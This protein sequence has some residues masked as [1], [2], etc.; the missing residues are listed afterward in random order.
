MEDIYS[1]YE[2]IV[3]LEVHIQLLTKSKAYSSDATEYGAAPNTQVSPVSLGLPGTLPV[4]NEKVLEFAVKI[5]LACECD[6][7]EENEFARKNYFYADL[8]KGYQITQHTTPIC[9]NGVVKIKDADGNPKEIHLERI[10]MEEDT[11]K[12]MHD[13]DPYDSLIDLNRAGTPLLEIV[14]HPDIRNSTEAYNY[15]YE[16]RKLVRY[17]EIC[18]GNM[19]EGSLR[20]DANISVRKKGTS[21]LGR[22]VEVKNMNSM[23]NVQKAIEFETRRQIDMLENGEVIAQETR[24]FDA[25]SGKTFAMRSKESAHDYRYFPEPDLPRVFVTQHFISEIRENMPPLPGE[26]FVKYT[27]EY[28]LPESDAFTITD[29][30]AEAL[31]F[32]EMCKTTSNRK[33]AANW[34]LVQIKSYLNEAGLH[35]GQFPLQPVQV[36]ELIGLIDNGKISHSAASQQVFPALVKAPS[37]TPL[38]IAEQLNLLQESN[39][40]TIQQFV[41]QAVES[42]PDKVEQYRNG[43]TG[44]LGL[45]MG[46]VMKLSKG[47]ADPKVA[48]ELVKKYLEQ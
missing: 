10:H 44:L 31:Y 43:K 41:I 12:S 27:Q 29:S 33:A 3:G 19:E 13:Q 28:G 22:K 47:K 14:S 36:T 24:N 5:G 45:F 34:L 48:S 37:S 17:L 4:M 9:T 8:P 42:M 40:D 20:C 23:R 26:L 38:A 11:G 35:I 7:R 46:E 32:E 1:A 18:D 25:T 39:I 15:L 2:T 21:E 6:I 30:K 16:I